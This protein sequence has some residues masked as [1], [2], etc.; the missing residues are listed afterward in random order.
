MPRSEVDYLPSIPENPE[1][2][3]ETPSPEPPNPGALE[4]APVPDDDDDDL[5][6]EAYALSNDQAWKFGVNIDL[7]DIDMWKKNDSHPEELAFLVS[8][9]K[10]QKTE[11]KL[12][13]LT[14][15]E[16]QQ[17]LE[18]KNKAIQSWLDT[19]TACRILRN[20]IPIKTFSNVDGS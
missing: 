20:Q 2:L 17:F 10:K 9:A 3:P 19:K 6:S 18:A 14:P 8:A 5:F 7:T 11:V 16:K 1:Q 4:N 12:A 15:Q 13:T